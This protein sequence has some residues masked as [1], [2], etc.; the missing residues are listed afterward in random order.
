VRTG[1]EPAQTGNR[2]CLRSAHGNGI[3][4]ARRR[5]RLG[6]LRRSCAPF[7]AFNRGR[8]RAARYTAQHFRSSSARHHT[9]LHVFSR[10]GYAAGQRSAS[11]GKLAG[12]RRAAVGFVEDGGLEECAGLVADDDR[13]CSA[14]RALGGISSGLSAVVADF[15]CA[16][17]RRQTR[18][19]M[20]KARN[21][22]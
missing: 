13:T 14:L 21:R 6:G 11:I 9:L 22:A 16:T 1:I 3:N 12:G 15:L 18:D 2:L 17:Q 4:L 10:Q 5:H 7:H 19:A 8:P 20:G